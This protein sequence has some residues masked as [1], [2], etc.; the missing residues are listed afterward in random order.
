MNLFILLIVAVA[1]IA[2][3][4]YFASRKSV[5][6]L[7]SKQVKKK[8]ENKERILE[9]LEENERMT[10][11]DVEKL[12]SVSDA[13]ATRYFNELEKER[14]VR[15]IGITGHAVYYVLLKGQR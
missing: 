9:F 13:T 10:N 4:A 8:M 3:G 2:L 7:I 6:G 5:D 12:L 1:G 15:Q 14:K 11:N